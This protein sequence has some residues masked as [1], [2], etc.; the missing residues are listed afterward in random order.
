MW[1]TARGSVDKMWSQGS[2]QGT[3]W[4]TWY[5]AFCS[6]WNLHRKSKGL[7]SLNFREEGG[8]PDGSINH[9]MLFVS[10]YSLRVNEVH[11]QW[12]PSAAWY[13]VHELV[14]TLLSQVDRTTIPSSLYMNGNWLVLEFFHKQWEWSPSTSHMDF[15]SSWS[16]YYYYYYV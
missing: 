7:I 6:N 15:C 11:F 12:N 1:M 2:H 13:S 4:Y 16:Y 5:A 14:Q 3:R 8:E 9:L 10:D